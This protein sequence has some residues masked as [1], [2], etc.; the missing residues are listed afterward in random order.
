VDPIVERLVVVHH[1]DA[2]QGSTIY[3]SS[4]G[5]GVRSPS[6]IA[7]SGLS[8]IVSGRF[9][10]PRRSGRFPGREDEFGGPERVLGAEFRRLLLAEA[11]YVLR[12]GAVDELPSRG[13][14]PRSR[15]P[16]SRRR[17]GGS[18]T[19]GV[20]RRRRPSGPTSMTPSVPIRRLWHR[21]RWRD[22]RSQC[23]RRPRRRGRRSRTPQW[24][25]A[26]FS[27]CEPDRMFSSELVDLT[28]HPP[29][30]SRRWK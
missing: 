1:L 18:A 9:T 26:W 29:P 14:R 3:S 12:D 28:H 2:D 19:P 7:W 5:A 23:C 17:R 4:A 20:P 16:P 15:P 8:S 11:A 21:R 10:R 22:R 13:G 6:I 30:T 24:T 25:I 27:L